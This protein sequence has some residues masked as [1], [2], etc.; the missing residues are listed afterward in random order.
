[1]KR[2]TASRSFS[3]PGSQCT[4][5]SFPD[6]EAP[7]KRV[8][9]EW[10]ALVD[11][12]FGTATPPKP[13]R[14]SSIKADQSRS[15]EAASPDVCVA[16]HCQAGLGRAPALVAIALMERGVMA[17]LDAIAYIRERRKGAFNA[18]QMAYLEAYSTLRK[19]PQKCRVQ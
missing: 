18:K 6:G 9:E 14:A 17:P 13:R 1:V 7:P 2:H 12:V 15:G 10:L 19:K 16:V 4:T 11:E 8:V 5:M 3:K